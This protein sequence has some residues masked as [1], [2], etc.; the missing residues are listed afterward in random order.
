MIAS[1]VLS[2][3][4]ACNNGE[5]K[6]AS[7]AP[8][9]AATPA[10]SA[11]S[12]PGE[13]TADGA[14][15]ATWEGGSL[16]YAPVR[17]KV[18]T[19]LIKLEADYLS[20]R[21]DTEEQEVNDQVNEAILTAEAKARGMADA[22]I[23]LKAEIDDKVGTPTESEV[24]EAY[25]QLARRLGGKPL[26]EVRAQV[27]RAVVQKK[28]A[29]R[30]GQY[31]E[32][33]RTKYKVAVTLPFPN[34]PKFPV[35]VD[36]DPFEGPATA[37]VTIV[38]FAEFQ[39]PYCGKADAVVKDILKNYDGKVRFV[40]RDFPLGFHE[41]AIPAAIAA[42][43]AGKQGKYWEMHHAFMQN[44]RA[45]TEPDLERT[46]QELGLNSTDWEACRKD[47]TVEAEIR[48]DMADGSELGVQG[49][50]AFFVNGIFLN[51]AQPYEK[52]QQIIDRELA[53]QKG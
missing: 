24:Q 37:P 4:L 20:Q 51:G 25:M 44:Q 3:L 43:C 15:V 39:C 23:L 35:S 10:A 48:K 16:T 32:E 7:S 22:K 42:N 18:G 41:N 21:F 28:Q 46:A 31:V 17:E 52:F 9:P 11:S 34:L 26:E 13:A 27:E 5:S 6:P 1:L 47:P 36:D 8:A 30:Y 29:E 14:T 45:L 49:T 40:F 12:T 53:A 38:Q 2:L 50:P 19:Q 33:L